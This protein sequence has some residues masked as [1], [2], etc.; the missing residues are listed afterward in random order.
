MLIDHVAR[1][2]FCGQGFHEEM[3]MLSNTQDWFDYNSC[4][5]VFPDL[6][7]F[8]KLVLFRLFSGW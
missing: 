5:K 8:L 3:S 7:R 4:C 2:V 1:A 6:A